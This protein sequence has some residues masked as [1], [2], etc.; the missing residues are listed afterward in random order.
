MW[1]RAVESAR[2]DFG[3]YTQQD[4]L[5]FIGRGGLEGPTFREQRPLERNPSEVVDSYNFHA[6]GKYGYLAFY[7]ARVTRKW[8]IKSFKLNRESD[9]RTLPSSH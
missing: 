9:P 8:I 1:I 2:A 5:S 3:L 7:Y 4:V 6:G